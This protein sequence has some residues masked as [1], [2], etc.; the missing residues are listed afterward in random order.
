MISLHKKWVICRGGT[1]SDSA[2]LATVNKEMFSMHHGVQARLTGSD[3]VVFSLKA[4]GI[5]AGR[6]EH[7]ITYRGQVIG[8]ASSL[9]C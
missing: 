8:Q 9:L 1:V 2:I 6:R 5:V 7:D 4:K 3:E